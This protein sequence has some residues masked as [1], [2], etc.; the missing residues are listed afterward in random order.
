MRDNLPKTE[1]VTNKSKLLKL[2]TDPAVEVSGILPI[3]DEKLYVTWTYVDSVVTP[4]N[5]TNVVIAAQTTALARLK[6]LEYLQKLGK[7]VQYFDTDSVFYLSTRGKDEYTPKLGNCLGDMTNEL[8]DYGP[9]AH[10]IE[11]VA[12]ADK[13]YAYKIR[14]SKGEIHEKCKVKGIT[15]NATTSNKLN[16]ESIKAIVLEHE[17]QSVIYPMITRTPLHDVISIPNQE[18]V[19]KAVHTKRRYVNNTESYPFG[20]KRQRLSM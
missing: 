17:T 1:I 10:V 16:F 14:D 12:A 7:R 13:F 5:M 2:L 8:D 18:K 20:Y 11:F 3:D 9:G 4:N 6:L 15:L 19:F